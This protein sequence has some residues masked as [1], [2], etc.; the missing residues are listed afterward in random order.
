MWLP[1]EGGVWLPREGGVWLPKERGLGQGA[2]EKEL[3]IINFK[4]YFMYI[5]NAFQVF[6]FLWS[7]TST[8]FSIEAKKRRLFLWSRVVHV[9]F[10]TT[11]VV[12]GRCHCQNCSVSAHKNKLNKRSLYWRKRV[13]ILYAISGRNTT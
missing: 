4:Q 13:N 6:N 9:H 3:D 1:R 11:G 12:R 10:L 2:K 7:V 5:V 8:L